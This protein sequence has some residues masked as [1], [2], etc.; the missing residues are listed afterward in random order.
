MD[1]LALD[2]VRRRLRIVGQSYLGVRAI[3]VARIAG[4]LDRD[5]DLDRESRPRRK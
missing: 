1:L 4:S 2:E 3:P 5:A